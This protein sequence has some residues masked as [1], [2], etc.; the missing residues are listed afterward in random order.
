[1]GI[2]E[3]AVIDG[4]SPVLGLREDV[5][6]TVVPKYLVGEIGSTGVNRARNR[7]VEAGDRDDNL[8]AFRCQG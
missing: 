5:G 1:L 7:F 2:V 8:C 6:K 4:K 3:P